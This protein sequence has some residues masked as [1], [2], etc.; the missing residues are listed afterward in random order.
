MIPAAGISILKLTKRYRDFVAVEDLTLEVSRGE[1]YGL[2]GRNGAGKTTT[3]KCLVGLLRPGSGRVLICGRD[4]EKEPSKAKRLIGY[5]PDRPFLYEK[6][7][8]AEFIGF[9]AEL[10][11]CAGP[12][13][14]GR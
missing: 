6:L 3:L 2:L 7:S 12:P 11:G 4:V 8:G 5:I 10:Y 1:L 13:M 14:T 9:A